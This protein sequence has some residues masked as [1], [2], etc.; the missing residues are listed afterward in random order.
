MTINGIITAE[1]PLKNAGSPNQILQGVDGNFYFTDTAGNKIG[2]FF[3]KA[4]AANY[5]SIPTKDSSPTAMTLGTDNQ[6]YFVETA[7]N[8]VG[9]FR[10]FAV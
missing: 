2:Q 7:G 1:Y 6:I 9:Q 10:Y 8:K 3:F 5:Y 4:H